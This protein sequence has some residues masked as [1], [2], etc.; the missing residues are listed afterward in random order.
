MVPDAEAAGA[1]HHAAARGDQV[2]ERPVVDEHL[3][4]LPRAG[5]D[6]EADARDGPVRPFR[7]AAAVIMSR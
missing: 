4:D 6:A 2:V 7:M 3:E 1:L 5:R